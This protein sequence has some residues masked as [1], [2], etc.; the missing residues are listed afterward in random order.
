MALH[1]RQFG[2][3]RSTQ[4]LSQELSTLNIEL[5]HKLDIE[6]YLA[7]LV[8]EHVYTDRDA[9]Q[10]VCYWEYRNRDTGIKLIIFN[11]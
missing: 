6:G 3:D 2:W 10:D 4:T 9:D 1:V 7:W 5:T 11:D 8:F